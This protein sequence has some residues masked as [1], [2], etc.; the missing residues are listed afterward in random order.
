MA[1]AA[2]A[3]RAAVVTGPGGPPLIGR[4]A[5]R[6]MARTELSKRIYHQGSSVIYSF[7]QK[8]VTFFDR[9]FEHVNSAMPGG[10]WALVVLGVLA[11]GVLGTVL[12]RVGPISR[13]HRAAAPLGRAVQTDHRKRAEELAAVG[14]WAGAI[15]ER[16]RAIAGHLE[17]R[18]I[19]P[20]QAGRTADELAV[21]AGR[22]LPRFASGLWSAARLFDDV[23]YGDR[24]GTPQGYAQLRQLDET[25]RAAR[26]AP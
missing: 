10:W 5:A 11:V 13:R 25:V 23:Y 7:L 20:P 15:R 16:L 14:D 17:E 8:I 6:E 18:A 21:E 19:V 12:A 22:A 1:A 26:D 4:N 9:L 3:C 2:P 24:A